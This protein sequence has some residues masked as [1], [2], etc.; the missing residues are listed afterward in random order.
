VWGK[1]WWLFSLYLAGIHNK[2]LKNL[3]HMIFNQHVGTT[4]EVFSNW[5]FEVR[6][7]KKT[8]L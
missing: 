5:D 1:L 8:M 6:I 4:E 3:L 2:R 7:G